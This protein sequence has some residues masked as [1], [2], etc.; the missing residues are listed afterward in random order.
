MHI[1]VYVWILVACMQVDDSTVCIVYIMLASLT[2][3]HT[4]CTLA[5]VHLNYTLTQMVDV[6]L[7]Y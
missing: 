2:P 6:E 1:A 4:L 5:L 3:L 7:Q